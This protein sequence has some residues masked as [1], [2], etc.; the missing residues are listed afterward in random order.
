M[1]LEP[2]KRP[3]DLEFQVA[4]DLG[5]LDRSA[6]IASVR[7]LIGSLTTKCGLSPFF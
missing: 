3:D 2:I 7:E 1:G 4:I 5:D 6:N